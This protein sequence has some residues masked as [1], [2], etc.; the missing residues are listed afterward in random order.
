MLKA[1]DHQA[2]D[3]GIRLAGILGA[4]ID[5]ASLIRRQPDLAIVSTGGFL[6]LGDTTHAI[7]WLERA[8]DRYDG[9]LL[10]AQLPNA[11]EFNFLR[12]DP[13]F[14]TLMGRMGIPARP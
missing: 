7:Q 1:T 13:R 4:E 9:G 6:G 8:I 3:L 11:E 12:D 14:V 10:A 2:P 5:I